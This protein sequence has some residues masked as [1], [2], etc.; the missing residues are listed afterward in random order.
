MNAKTSKF[1]AV[2]AVLAVAFAGC[3]ILLN[4]Q[5]DAATEEVTKSTY[6]ANGANI[7]SIE[8]ED[9]PNAKSVVKYTEGMAITSPN[10]YFFSEDASV[11]MSDK[12]TLDAPVMF[13]VLNGVNID[14]IA[15]TD[16]KF[17]AFGLIEF[18]NVKSYDEDDEV[19]TLNATTTF[20]SNGYAKK[21]TDGVG[22]E[23]YEGVVTISYQVNDTFS[24][25]ADKNSK[26]KF[27]LSTIDKLD[28][29]SNT[30]LT[31]EIGT[32]TIKNPSVELKLKDFTG[33]ITDGTATA[34]VVG[35]T[36]TITEAATVGA[37]TIS[38]WTAGM[39]KSVN[40]YTKVTVAPIEFTKE[41]QYATFGRNVE[42]QTATTVEFTR[43]VNDS[44]KF[45]TDKVIKGGSEGTTFTAGENGLEIS[46]GFVLT[47]AT[48]FQFTGP[49]K[50]SGIAKISD[51][52]LTI[53]QTDAAGYQITL[54]ELR[55]DNVG[56]NR[57]TLAANIVIEGQVTVNGDIV[58]LYNVVIAP[59]SNFNVT[60][61]TFANTSDAG[62]VFVGKDSSFR[63][64]AFLEIDAT[65]YY[66]YNDEKWENKAFVDSTGAIYLN[67]NKVT[68]ASAAV[69]AYLYQIGAGTVSINSSICST[70]STYFIY[71][72]VIPYLSLNPVDVVCQST[73]ADDA[74][75]S[76]DKVK[77]T[78][79]ELPIGNQARYVIDYSTGVP[80][81]TVVFTELYTVQIENA[82]TADGTQKIKVLDE[83]GEEVAMVKG[84]AVEEQ[85]VLVGYMGEVRL[86][87]LGEYTIQGI[88]ENNK[89]TFK[90]EV[91]AA[92]YPQS[93]KISFER[94]TNYSQSFEMIRAYLS[95]TVYD[96][97]VISYT[98]GFAVELTVTLADENDKISEGDVFMYY[99]SGDSTVD[100]EKEQAIPVQLGKKGEAVITG[101]YT[102][103]LL[104]LK[105]KYVL[106]YK[107]AVV[108]STAPKGVD[109]FPTT[110]A[111]TDQIA[112]DPDAW[113]T[114]YEITGVKPTTEGKP[115]T[116]SFKVACVLDEID[117]TFEFGAITGSTDVPEITVDFTT[118]CAD[119][120]HKES[121][122]IKSTDE[123]ADKT[124][125][126]CV[127][128]VYTVSWEE[129]DGQLSMM[130]YIAVPE[131]VTVTPA[132]AEGL[133]T[134]TTSVDPSGS[135]TVTADKE[136][137]AQGN[138]V[139]LTIVPAVG[140]QL[141]SITASDGT[142]PVTIA[143]DYT[144][145]MPATNVTV[146]AVFEAVEPTVYTKGDEIEAEDSL[147]FNLYFEKAETMVFENK[148]PADVITFTVGDYSVDVAKGETGTLV[149]NN[150][151]NASQDTGASPF[152]K[153]APLE[154]T[155]K[156]A[157]ISW[158]A[159]Q[160]YK[161]DDSKVTGE[162]ASGTISGTKTSTSYAD[163][164]GTL[165]T[166]TAK[167]TI[168]DIQ[169]TMITY[170]VT[171]D[172][173]DHAAVTNF[174]YSGYYNK[175]MKAYVQPNLGF[176][177][178]GLEYTYIDED[179]NEVTKDA[180][181]D[182]SDKVGQEFY[183]YYMPAADIT[184]RPIV[185][186]PTYEVSFVNQDGKLVDKVDVVPF[187]A[188]PISIPAVF[189]Y[190]ATA[191]TTDAEIE[192]DFAFDAKTQTVT[193]EMPAAP[194]E[195]KVTYDAGGPYSDDMEIFV[196]KATGGVKVTII[197]NNDLPIQS[198]YLTIRYYVL[199]E[200]DGIYGL[201]PVDMKSVEFATSGAGNIE[202]MTVSLA[203]EESYDAIYYVAATFVSL[204]DDVL[205]SDT[206]A[207]KM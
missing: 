122:K 69:V 144:F 96:V 29:Y 195:I 35:F 128:E 48:N 19:I 139:T 57:I 23:S 140:Y 174:D 79:G 92:P 85:N 106:F 30:T 113:T 114:G 18:V 172:P 168:T 4:E 68:T 70:A 80:E 156:G 108:N 160:F 110:A 67:Q 3:A 17:T 161:A 55:F 61:T 49:A 94:E 130:R 12:V 124:V 25:T 193:F 14:V 145:T 56:A 26:S 187:T 1:L 125:K 51:K 32:V 47:D 158:F 11:I 73:I 190:V 98:E 167:V 83:N 62:K 123:A 136:K 66:T 54:E 87:Y 142:N 116:G 177:V 60:G 200:E 74:S 119:A 6:P 102:E 184:L 186:M 179:G 154:L 127:G 27:V 137:Y 176:Q 52:S 42:M 37:F 199:V 86:A 8:L 182:T 205:K 95:D 138:K 189:G 133:L 2:L 82:Y 149:I 143:N 76:L 192:G 45:V 105:S 31:G 22:S 171:V 175:Y 201:M 99:V 58:N 13:F 100:P 197:S 77:Y 181:W 103:D 41:G 173:D 146:T 117:V 203:G 101:I 65:V 163:F 180:I 50:I 198:G 43:Y 20:T 148:T 72:Q 131:Q 132:A 188:D 183:Y 84:D 88:N 157:N 118:Y 71:N 202:S 9:S 185:A 109:F 121:V 111:T 151:K 112:L 28:I 75:I 34:E 194:V 40:D 166:D 129:I 150:G 153:G 78:G 162:K 152:A 16:E 93:N 196:S 191:A 141:K 134:V 5:N 165:S 104:Y 46:G 53:T 204:S 64:K 97:P 164:I 36:G 207:Y 126:V 44:Y 206:L 91:P 90:H 135:G 107:F 89:Y 33:K 63:T 169:F 170:Y 81:F 120:N 178:F 24:I 10:A 59:E 21:I 159:Y 115:Y 7:V 155:I 38:G 39:L 147:K 15:P